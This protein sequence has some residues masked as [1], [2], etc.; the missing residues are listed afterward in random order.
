MPSWHVLYFKS[1]EVTVVNAVNAAWHFLDENVSRDGGW[2]A[3]RLDGDKQWKAEGMERHLKEMF[4]L[5]QC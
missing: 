2:K 4:V 5:L 1:V 3:L